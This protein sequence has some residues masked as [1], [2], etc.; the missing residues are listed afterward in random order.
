MTMSD[1]SLVDVA[2]FLKCPECH[3]T[4]VKL[5]IYADGDV[6]IVCDACQA[7]A[8]GHPLNYSDREYGSD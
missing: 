1:A 3:R 7:T 5:T 4:T 8:I 2:D 6:G